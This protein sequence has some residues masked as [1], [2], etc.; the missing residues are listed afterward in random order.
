MKL[1][2]LLIQTICVLCLYMVESFAQGPEV[3]VPKPSEVV[4]SDGAYTYDDVP[5]VKV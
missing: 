5:E 3:V 4:F 1:R 2:V